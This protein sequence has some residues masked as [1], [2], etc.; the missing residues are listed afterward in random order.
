MLRMKRGAMGRKG[1]WVR[2]FFVL[3]TR[4]LHRFERSRS[5]QTLFGIEKEV[6]TRTKCSCLDFVPIM[7]ELLTY[8]SAICFF[9]QYFIQ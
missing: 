9:F 6:R 7:T 1:R 2:R 4:G 5:G 8:F 3:T